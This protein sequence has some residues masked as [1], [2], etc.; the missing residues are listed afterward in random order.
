[1]TNE[2]LTNEVRSLRRLVEALVTALAPDETPAERSLIETLDALTASV[3]DTGGV[4]SSLHSTV[5]SLARRPL[6]SE[7]A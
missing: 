7:P 6:V 4:V 3:D 2:E 5:S 1:M